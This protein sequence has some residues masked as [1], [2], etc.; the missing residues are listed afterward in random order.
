MGE[1]ARSS[2]RY[3]RDLS[4][5]RCGDLSD[6]LLDR[7]ARLSDFV[8]RVDVRVVVWIAP[9]AR[10]ANRNLERHPQCIVWG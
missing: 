5:P 2:R 10:L 9:E 6:Y 3:S 4:N 8:F 7:P 1:L